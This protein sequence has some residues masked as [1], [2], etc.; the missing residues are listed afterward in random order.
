[1]TTSERA[2]LGDL[3]AT[4][5]SSSRTIKHPKGNPLALAE[6]LL[7]ACV[8]VVV[9]R[10]PE[11]YPDGWQTVTAEQCDLSAFRPGKD[12]L[13]LVGGHGI[14]LVDEDTKVPGNSVDNLP[15]FPRFG[16]TLTPSGGRHYVVPSCGLGKM[17]LPGVGDYVG[18]R[19]DGTSRLLGFLPGSVRSK[20]PG[21]PYVEEHAWDVEACLAATPDEGLVEALLAAGGSREARPVDYIDLSPPRDPSL[22]LHPYA[23]AAIGRELARLD[24]CE[25]LGLENWDI[26]THAVACQLIRFANSGWSG[27]S[28]DE[29]E[30]NLLGHAPTDDGFGPT[31]HAE[32][33]ASACNTVGEGGRRCPDAP[34]DDSDEPGAGNGKTPPLAVRLREHVVA[35]YD[36]FPAGDDGRIYVQ[37]KKGGRA[38]LLS[39]NFVMRAADRIGD[40]AAGLSAAAV[41]AA[42]VLGARSLA[43]P[44]RTLA[45]RVHY[46]PGRIVL[47]LGQRSSTRCVVVTPTGW[48][49]QDVPPRDVVF[50]AANAAL[51]DPERGGSVDDLRRLL[52]W[53]S[54]DPRWLLVKGW[55]PCSLLADMPRPAVFLLGPQGSAKSTTGRFITGVVDPKP[56]G[57]LGGGFGKNRADDE[58]KVLRSYIP[59]WDNVSNLSDEGADFL[60]RMVTGDLIEKRML[61]SDDDL[62]SIRYRRTA[63]ITG[64]N[65]PRGVKPDTLDRLILLAVQRIPGER[66]SEGRLDAEWEQV[67]PRVLAGVLDLAAR[68]LAGLPTALNPR[69]LRMADY[70]EALWA[71]G[72]DLYDAYADNVSTA[73]GDMAH[74]DPFIGALVKWLRSCPE[75]EWEGTADAAVTAGADYAEFAPGEVWWPP[76][77]RSLVRQLNKCSE[78]LRA[79]GVTVTSRKSNNDRLKRF[80]LVEEG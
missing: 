25:V 65:M 22:G 66:V 15:P 33:W 26:K 75:G 79:V 51:P 55:L 76:N 41:E 36:L 28:M 32:K 57:V 44:P 23:A 47:D 34:A 56:S 80:V 10:Y 2:G 16:V 54:D 73:R 63:V 43:E 20:Y 7:K 68:M 64:I 11:K 52:R 70:A 71:I 12:A 48:K 6:R 45:L 50:Q 77:G 18:G 62:V 78:L 19:P 17:D 59:A 49:V 30:A 61:Y 8:P 14:D 46:Q 24:A 35:H 40:R 37:N 38:E 39:S 1:M 60:S 31:E 69:E 4:K 74:D 67:Q 27:Y 9:V 29:A 5:A 42:K 53:Q 13:A 3:P 72:P 21:V 58:V